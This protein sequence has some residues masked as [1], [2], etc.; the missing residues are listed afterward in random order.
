MS[1]VTKTVTTY[2]ARDNGRLTAGKLAEVL[3]AWPS[4]VFITRMEIGDSQRDG[5]WWSVKGQVSA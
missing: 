1:N 5:S 2:E 3:K 4:E